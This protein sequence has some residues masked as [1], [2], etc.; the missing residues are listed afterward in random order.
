MGLKLKKKKIA[1]IGAGYMSTEHVKTFS[2]LKKY[3][4]VSGI[5]NRTKSKAQNLAK[6]YNIS[7][8]ASSIDSLYENTKADAVVISINQIH[9]LTILP[10]VLEYPWKI[11]IEKPLGYNYEHANKIF[12]LVKKYKKQNDIVVALNRRNYPTTLQAI[13]IIKN[14]N[15]TRIV[16]VEDQENI[17]DPKMLKKSH[18]I[19]KNWM[20]SNSIHII[21]YFNIFCRGKVINIKNII[22]TKTN[23]SGL[24]L[25]HIRFSSGDIGIYK[26][27]WNMPGPWSVTIITKKIFLELKP[28]EKLFARSSLQKVKKVKINNPEPGDLKTGLKN[29]A[30]Q[31][32]N[33]IHNKKHNLVSL[34]NSLNIMKFI[35]NIYQIKK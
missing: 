33:F 31:F 10:K 7:F 34:E 26:C 4:L 19:R 28:L 16:S 12:S 1:F 2:R 9:L 11:M 15:D 21:D 20:Y 5:F 3:F 27:I 25:S 29:Q 13:E 23:K 8:V 14:T 22:K 18:L 35:K 32:Y 6:K 30:D 17:K 24:M